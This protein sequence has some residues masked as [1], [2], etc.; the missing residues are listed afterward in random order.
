[1]AD[2]GFENI[3]KPGMLQSVGKVMTIKKGA[4]MKGIDWDK[5]ERVF[6]EQGFILKED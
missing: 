2:S 3:A 1:M 5:V 4:K 6:R